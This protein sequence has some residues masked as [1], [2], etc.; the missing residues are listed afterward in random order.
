MVTVTNYAQKKNSDGKKFF[1]IELT[2]EVEFAQSQQGR[3]YA[4]AR[5]CFMSTT[6]DEA[7]CK[8]LIGKQM[9]GNIKKIPVEEYEYTVPKTG[10]VITLD[11]RYEYS[12]DEDNTSMEAAVFQQE[13]SL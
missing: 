1:S 12:P 2:G 8:S 4:T 5:K 11:F 7:T 10:E 3:P 6:F 13:L 9:A